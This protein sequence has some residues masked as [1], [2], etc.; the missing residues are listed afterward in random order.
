MNSSRSNRAAS[1]R[2]L[3]WSHSWPES[4]YGFSSL[5]IREPLTANERLES[6]VVPA[7]VG[8][9]C[10]LRQGSGGQAGAASGRVVWVRCVVDGEDFSPNVPCLSAGG[11]GASSWAVVAWSTPLTQHPADE[12]LVPHG[13]MLL[14]CNL[15]VCEAGANLPDNGN[16][17]PPQ[18][19]QQNRFR[20]P[21]SDT[22]VASGGRRHPCVAQAESGNC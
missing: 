19:R 18:L 14:L 1:A 11:S 12:L 21:T 16:Q 3:C 8:W 17:C 13:V 10:H 6:A 20:D 2:C 7:L 9:R 22:R 5:T 4:C 15:E